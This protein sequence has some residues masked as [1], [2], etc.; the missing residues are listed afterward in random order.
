MKNPTQ[1]KQYKTCH[2]C[3][4]SSNPINAS[5]CELC[6]ENLL[7]VVTGEQK[8]NQ[9]KQSKESS[10]GKNKT[11][12]FAILLTITAVGLGAVFSS[13]TKPTWQADTKALPTGVLRYWGPP[14]GERLMSKKVANAVGQGNKFKALWTDTDSR[15]S[16]EELT[17]KQIS[18]VLHEKAQFPQ[19]QERAKEK[20][21]EL[22]GVPYA[23]DGIAYIVNQKVDDVDYLTIEQLEKIYRGEITNWEEVGGENRTITPILLS[24]LGRNSLFLDFKGKLNPNTRYVKNRKKAIDV[25][26]SNN[27]ALFYTSATLAPLERG[28]DIIP[29]K[30][31]N[32]DIV[33][34]VVDGKPNQ[35]AFA[36]GSYPQIRTLFAIYRKGEVDQEQKM[37]SAFIDYLTSR[38][39]QSIVKTAGFVPLYY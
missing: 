27:G 15:D 9:Q 19:H 4:Y 39:G 12:P 17:D 26:R 35:S 11:I 29:L 34:P 20:G 33:P 31:E 16:I 18:I 10:T 23:L 8:T 21:V 3:G 2:E 25:L 1:V 22:E 7:T 37:V 24:G 36:D 13:L 32:G 5:N 28:V 30:N 14:C 6:E 38:E